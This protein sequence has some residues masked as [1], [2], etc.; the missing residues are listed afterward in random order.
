MKSRIA[1]SFVLAIFLNT[2]AQA[3]TAVAPAPT[4]ETAPQEGQKTWTDSQATDYE[5]KQQELMDK[6]KDINKKWA[7]Y[8][9][10]KQAHL[11]QLENAAHQV[12]T[13]TYTL[14]KRLATVVDQFLSED[15]LKEIWGDYSSYT[16]HVPKNFTIQLDTVNQVIGV[17]SDDV[18]AKGRP[19]LEFELNKQ[20]GHSVETKRLPDG[21]ETHKREK[22]VD[23]NKLAV[24]FDTHYKPYVLRTVDD[25]EATGASPATDDEIQAITDEWNDLEK[26]RD[27][28]FKIMYFFMAFMMCTFG[29]LYTFFK[30]TQ[31]EE[32]Q[33]E[34]KKQKLMRESANAMSQDFLNLPGSLDDE[35]NTINPYQKKLPTTITNN[36]TSSSM[37]FTNLAEVS[38]NKVQQL[39]QKACS[40]SINDDLN[41]TTKSEQTTENNAAQNLEQMSQGNN[42]QADQ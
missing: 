36:F 8:I 2:G 37:P 24:N 1:L 28:A 40:T 42:G 41:T 34:I 38:Y 39:K 10:E 11:E 6:Q 33:A 18:D 23:L 25:Q 9:K 21:S 29:L 22:Y 19:L 30:M 27:L 4:P 14:K 15:S 13:D 20:T 16:Q 35:C 26:Q 3:Q 31:S 32:H 5:H 7:K 17:K 12:V